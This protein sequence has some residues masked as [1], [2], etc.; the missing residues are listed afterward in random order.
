MDTYLANTN[1]KDLL[2]ELKTSA[3]GLSDTEAEK[4]HL[5]YGPNILTKSSAN[6]T[7]R[8]LFKQVKNSLFYVLLLA[9]I[10]SFFLGS[11]NDAYIISAVLLINVSL[12]FYEENKS[13][14]TT[15]KLQKLLRRHVLVK[16]NNT[17]V[18][19]SEDLL[20][21]GDVVIVKE[22]DIVPAD[23]RIIYADNL[24]VNEATLSGEST[25]QFK[26]LSS[27][28]PSSKLLFAGTTIE[29]G[30]AQALVIAT[31]QKT[32][33]G[34]IAHLSDDTEKSTQYETSLRDF[35]S[36]L[37]KIILA[38]LFILFVC[39]ILLHNN[40]LNLLS[41]AL[42]IIALAITIIPEALPVIATV[43]LSSGAMYLAKNHVLTK[44]LSATEDFGNV[45]I[46]CTD[47]TGTIT[48]N[49]MTVTDVST[50]EKDLLKIIALSA[51]SHSENTKPRSS[52]DSAILNYF[53][54]HPLIKNLELIKEIPFD[55]FDRR[56]RYL[57][58]DN[59]EYLI[60][61]VGSPETLLEFSKTP[62][63]ITYINK[64]K[65]DS[66]SGLRHLGFSYK[67]IKAI[68]NIDLTKEEK[69]MIFLG[70]ITFEDTL[71]KNA[72][73]T[74]KTAQKLGVQI[75]ILSGDNPEVTQYVAKQIGL[76]AQNNK[77]YIGDEIE[78][79]SDTD[80]EKIAQENSAFARLNPEQKYRIVRL[81]K[82]K[83]VVAY[84]GD[85]IN[86]APALK[87]ADVAIAVNSATD[88]AKENADIV[89][90]RNDISVIINGLKY[91]RVIFANIN[92][93]IRYTMINNFGNFFA[94]AILFLFAKELPLNP[95][96]LL[97]ISLLTDL[98][99]VAIATDNVAASELAK[100]SHYSIMRLMSSSFLL[101]LPTTL[102]ILIY[103]YISQLIEPNYA[104]TGL[105][106]FLILSSLMIIFSVRSRD[107][108]Y[109]SIKMSLPLFLGIILTFFVALAIVY[110]PAINHVFGFTF[111]PWILVEIII[112]MS[113]IYLF[114]LDIFK[115]YI[116][117]GAHGNNGGIGN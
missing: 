117:K 6:S 73:S 31:G 96:Q 108:F 60:V 11:F 26:L 114:V 63:K 3:S 106:L 12:G 103:Y 44:N 68:D 71:R 90:L 28:K 95:G 21:P 33:L 76:L 116:I 89:L 45:N 112:I 86:D 62:D 79:L 52:Y 84:Q 23:L 78:K 43:T 77:V 30:E 64:I 80:L 69:D 1:L 42:F 32:K 101:G 110:L 54:T 91:G 22:G 27:L 4:R 36:L 85:G 7:W 67:K 70:L 57:L 98:P 56:A 72:A 94:L 93:Y 59:N 105:F 58:K 55:P 47:K 46:L 13:Q 35:S 19:I 8:I 41:I 9:D 49:K 87:L 15:E 24:E 29:K 66:L 37:I 5:I 111:L 88:I 82:K 102:F 107:F 75:K 92:K 109:K 50:N 39:K 100:P 97:L 14:K 2:K 18:L 83:N 115:I 48:E 16:R 40:S 81:L 25:P 17:Q 51:I 10:I 53:S 20:V 99:L 104:K 74:V 61:S 65:S 113:V 34:Q 38:A